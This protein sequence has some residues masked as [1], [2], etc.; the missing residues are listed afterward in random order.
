L[1]IKKSFNFSQ[2]SLGGKMDWK[3]FFST[4]ALI[5]LAELG[6]KTQLSAL[7][8]TAQSKKPVLIFISASLALVIITLLGVMIGDSLLRLI[9]EDYIRRLASALFIGLG[10]LLWFR[11]I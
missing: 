11:V 5:F 1:A 3:L 10:V 8:L 7:M 6:D 2:E 4:F 9:P